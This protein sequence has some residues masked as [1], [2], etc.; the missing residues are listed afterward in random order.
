MKLKSVTRLLSRLTDLR[1]RKEEQARL[2]LANG[3]ARHA[4]ASA[5]L[6]EEEIRLQRIET[7]LPA[8]FRLHLRQIKALE[9]PTDR[10]ATLVQAT[11]ADRKAQ[12]DQARQTQTASLQVQC[13]ATEVE[14]LRGQY[15]QARRRRQVL[16]AMGQTQIQAERKRQELRHEDLSS[17]QPRI[18]QQKDMP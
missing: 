7:V 13:V 16:E 12:A 10:F 1:L 6:E 11:E 5:L 2:N 4:K 9:R 14:G 8:I 17:D 18:R 15:L 3:Q